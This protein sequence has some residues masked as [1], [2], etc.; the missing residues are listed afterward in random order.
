VAA[1]IAAPIATSVSTAAAAHNI[2]ISL[3][4]LLIVDYSFHSF[5]NLP[6]DGV[7]RL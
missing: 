4:P 2:A 5:R 1:A 3:L 7:H 6:V